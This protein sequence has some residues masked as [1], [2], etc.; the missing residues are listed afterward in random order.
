MMSYRVVPARNASA[1]FRNRIA[2]TAA[3]IAGSSLLPATKRE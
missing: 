1:K 3:T 2:V